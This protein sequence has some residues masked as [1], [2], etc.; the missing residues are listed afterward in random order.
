VEDILAC[1][2]RWGVG[3]LLALS[4]QGPCTFCPT[5]GHIKEMLWGLALGLEL[6]LTRAHVKPGD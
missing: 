6:T 1:S 4:A 5:V 3:A 2:C